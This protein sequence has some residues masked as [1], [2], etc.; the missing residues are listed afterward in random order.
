MDCTEL[1]YAYINK[2]LEEIVLENIVFPKTT[3]IIV[4]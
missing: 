1:E 2:D 4:R 3:K